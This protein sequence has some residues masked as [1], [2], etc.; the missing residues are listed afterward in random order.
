MKTLFPGDVVMSKH[1][2]VELWFGEYASDGTNGLSFGF[3]V[4]KGAEMLVISTKS[5]PFVF[6]LVQGH[7][8]HVHVLNMQKVLP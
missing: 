5:L 8:G 4:P 6:V 3:T 1:G 2:S 7:V